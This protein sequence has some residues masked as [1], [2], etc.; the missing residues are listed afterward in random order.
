MPQSA[1][2]FPPLRIAFS[3]KLGTHDGSLLHL[4]EIRRRE[5]Y[6]PR[7]TEDYLDTKPGALPST[8]LSTPRIEK[9]KKEKRCVRFQ[10]LFFR[11]PILFASSFLLIRGQQEQVMTE[12]TRRKGLSVDSIEC[13]SLSIKCAESNVGGSFSVRRQFYAR[14]PKDGGSTRQWQERALVFTPGSLPCMRA[15]A[16]TL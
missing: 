5:I 16:C 6:W 9:K 11:V 13:C 1:V 2:R 14:R 8:L 12:I 7:D 15:S 3:V 10:A 4:G